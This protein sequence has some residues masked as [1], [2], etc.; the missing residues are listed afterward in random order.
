MQGLDYTEIDWEHMTIAGS[1]RSGLD[2]GVHG[3]LGIEYMFTGKMGFF[4]E[5][6]ARYANLKNFESV[7]GTIESGEGTDTIE[8]TLY[9]GSQVAG[10]QSIGMF[11]IVAPG[12][13]LPGSFFREPKI[14]LSSLSIRAG[15][16]I[17]I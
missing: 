4:V 7:I 13:P 8:G 15:F 12:D 1:E 9:I 10:G 6:S 2:L 5:A 14:D 11:T 16:R 3:N 17:R